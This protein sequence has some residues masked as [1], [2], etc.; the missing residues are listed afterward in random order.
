M[1]SIWAYQ[2]T[3]YFCQ[4]SEKHFEKTQMLCRILKIKKESG[5]GDLSIMGV[6]SIFSANLLHASQNVL[7]CDVAI[8]L[9][10]CNCEIQYENALKICEKAT[11]I[12]D[13]ADDEGGLAAAA[14]GEAR[15]GLDAGRRRESQSS[16]KR[17]RPAHHG[18]SPARCSSRL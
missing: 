4:I 16:T 11:A 8:S 15:L 1:G 14:A 2:P 12:L 6:S 17:W 13:E 18:E 7:E 3:N 5:G 9:S 10:P